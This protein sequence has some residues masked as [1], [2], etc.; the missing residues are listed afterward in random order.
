MAKKQTGPV[1]G[2]IKFISA[3]ILA[4]LILA[5]IVVA[6]Q[7]YREEFA[8]GTISHVQLSIGSSDL[9][10][11]EDL[12]KA[13]VVVLEKVS[14]DFSGCDLL[15]LSYA[16]DGYSTDPENLRWLNGLTS[17]GGGKLTQCIRF[18]SAEQW[19]ADTGFKE[20]GD[21]DYYDFWLARENGGDWK[22]MTWGY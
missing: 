2:F 5:V 16:G 1:I 21:K 13:A 7:I 10:S 19:T 4:S 8:G 6:Y 14:D 18:C 12:S 20:K 9:F 22:L 17:R 3:F 15:K 11:D